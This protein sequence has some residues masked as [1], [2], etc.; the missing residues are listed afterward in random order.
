MNAK[1]TLAAAISIA[2]PT[3][4]LGADALVRAVHASPDAP[5]VDILVDDAIAFGAVPYTA[6]SPYAALPAPASY[7]IK[8]RPTGQPGPDVIDADVPVSADTA[9]TVVAAN[10]LASIQPLVFIDDLSQVG[11]R[12]RIRFIHASPNAPAVNIVLAGTNTILFDTVSFTESGGYIEVPGG[13]YDLEVR[14]S[15][16]NALALSLPGLSFDNNFVYTAFAVGLVGS[17]STPLSAVLAVDIP[18]PGVVSLFAAGGLVTL[19]R[20]R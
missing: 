18:S 14:L 6:A 4:A 7:N 9:Y 1:L 2:L 3:T 8:V 20:R 5:V 10:T 15:S 11:D 17:D 13:I 12:A 16:N 19:R